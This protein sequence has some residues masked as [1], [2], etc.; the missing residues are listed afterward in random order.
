VPKPLNEIENHDRR[1]GNM[2]NIKV[3]LFDRYVL[4]PLW[5]LYIVLFVRYFING[6]WVLGGFLVVM[7]FLISVIGQ[8]LHPDKTAREMARGT[9]P[10]KE[11]TDTDPNLDDLSDQEAVLISRANFRLAGLIGITAI[12]LSLFHGA[13]WYYGV[14]IG[15]GAWFLATFVIPTYSLY[16]IGRRIRKRH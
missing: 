6:A 10:T 9:T 8:G 16:L 2:T 5:V 12:A 14:L 1:H 7:W 11:E 13:R 3:S 4:K 15:G